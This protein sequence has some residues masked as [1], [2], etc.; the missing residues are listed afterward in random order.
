MAQLDMMKPDMAI[1]ASGNV[2]VMFQELLDG[3]TP[4]NG[5]SERVYV[6]KWNGTS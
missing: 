1:D 4:A 6:W 2:Y 3:A 5:S